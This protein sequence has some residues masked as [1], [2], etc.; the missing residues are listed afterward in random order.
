MEKRWRKEYINAFFS[1]LVAKIYDRD[2]MTIIARALLLS[3]NR[4][5]LSSGEDIFSNKIAFF[6]NLKSRKRFQKVSQLWGRSSKEQ[7][8]VFG[9]M[10]EDTNNSAIVFGVELQGLSSSCFLFSFRFLHQTTFPGSPGLVNG[11]FHQNLLRRSL[12][13]RQI[14]NSSSKNVIYSKKTKKKSLHNTKMKRNAK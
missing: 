10:F 14:V 8:L 13:L 3:Q 2:K 6:L 7:W 4:F 5:L 11:H 9:P 12:F 1:P